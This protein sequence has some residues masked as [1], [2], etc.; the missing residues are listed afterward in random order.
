MKRDSDFKCQAGRL[1]LK[2]TVPYLPYLPD[3]TD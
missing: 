1:A 3:A 2:V